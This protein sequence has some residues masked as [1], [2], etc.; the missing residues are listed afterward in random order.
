MGLSHAVETLAA[1]WDVIRADLGDDTGTELVD[2]VTQFVREPVPDFAAEIA[3]QIAR[4]L[5]DALPAQH[6][7]RQALSQPASRWSSGPVRSVG[8]LTSWLKSSEMLYKKVRPDEPLPTMDEI[9]RGATGW[10]LAEDAVTEEEMIELG[11]NPADVDL[12]R[13]EDR[14]GRYQWPA[15]QFDDTG[16]LLDLVRQVN[17]ILDVRDDPWGV[18]DWW[19]GGNVWLRGVPAE[20]IGQIDDQD[21][22]DAALGERAAGVT[23]A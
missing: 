1:D 9:M 19:L 17:R 22:I 18:A 7:F 16:R 5:S 23:H 8:E 11:Q 21:L 14:D 2:L 13:L 4:L 10:L 15:F 20:L 6:P 12:I 3:E